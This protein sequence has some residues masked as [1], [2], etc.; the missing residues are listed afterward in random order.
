MRIEQDEDGIFLAECPALPGRVSEAK[1][2][3]EALANIKDAIE[4]YIESLRRH[5]EPVQFNRYPGEF[6]ASRSFATT[7]GFF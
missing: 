6:P 7:A 5:D 2:R 3:T 1:T 4:G